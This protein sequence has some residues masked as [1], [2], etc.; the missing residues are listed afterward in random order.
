[1]NCAGLLGLA[2]ADGVVNELILDTPKSARESHRTVK[3]R[4]PRDPARDRAVRA[5]LLV[6][7]GV[8]GQASGGRAGLTENSPDYY[9]LWSLERVAAVFGLQT[10]GNKDWYGWGAEFAI[11]QQRS[12]G[13]WSGSYAEGGVDTSF[14]LLFLQRSNLAQDLT[15]K[16][17]GKVLDPGEVAL[18]A[19]GVRG[20]EL[21]S[22]NSQPTP[23]PAREGAGDK[24]GSEPKLIPPEKFVPRVG[25]NAA[26]REAQRLSAELVQAAPAQRD[27]LLEKLKES[28]GLVHTRALAIAI[29]HLTGPSKTKARDALAERVARMTASTLEDKLQDDNLEIR[30]AAALACAMKDEKRLIPNVIRLLEDSE[31]PVIR[32]AHVA[33]KELTGQDFGP[34]GDASRAESGKAVAAWKSWW[35]KQGGSFKNAEDALP[36]KEKLQGAWLMTVLERDGKVV[37]KAQLEKLRIRIVFKGDQVTFEYPDHNEVGTYKLEAATDPKSIDVV[38]ELDTSKGIY[39]L[40]GDSLR[41]CGAPAAEER[42]AEFATRRGTKQALYVLKRQKP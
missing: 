1:M 32:A 14:A 3:P 33:L 31:P 34:T 37:P 16:L 4:M 24:S 25:Q 42:P 10:I 28:R 39:A 22:K 26:D 11:A 9:F 41:I 36:D 30:R 7:G 29:P 17:R 2:V 23:E 12:D 35:T 8:I 5:G 21:A 38:T 6:L 27:A 19:G 18:K 15:S 13:S 20:S 40:E